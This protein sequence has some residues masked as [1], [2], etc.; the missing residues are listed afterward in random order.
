[1]PFAAVEEADLGFVALRTG[2]FLLVELLESD[3][4]RAELA[5]S[6]RLLDV[7]ETLPGR[8]DF[9]TLLTTVSL[10]ARISSG[11]RKLNALTQML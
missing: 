1:M 9:R 11:F 3:F 2:A 4:E 6:L 8:E 7:A 10:I 5:A